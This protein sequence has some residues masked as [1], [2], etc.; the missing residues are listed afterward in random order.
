MTVLHEWVI[1]AKC[2]C[3]YLWT[4]PGSDSVT[5]KCGLSSIESGLFAGNAQDV[6]DENEFTQA[7]ADDI[8]CLITDLMLLRK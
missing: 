4:N 7:V 2:E 1:R 3:G 5:C 6:T 8:S